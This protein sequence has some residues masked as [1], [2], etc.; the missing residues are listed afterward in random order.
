[1]NCSRIRDLLK[2]TINALVDVMSPAFYSIVDIKVSRTAFRKSACRDQLTNH[3]KKSKADYHQMCGQ[4]R[5]ILHLHD[6]IDRPKLEEEMET[7][8]LNGKLTAS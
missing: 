2:N 8:L 3:L 5:F 1:M 6:G 7:S 4:P